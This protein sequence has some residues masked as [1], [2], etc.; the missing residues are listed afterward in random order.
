MP[1]KGYKK[2]YPLAGAPPKPRDPSRP[3]NPRE[4]VEFDPDVYEALCELHCTKAEIAAV[5]NMSDDTLSR[6]IEDHYGQPHAAIYAQKLLRGNVSLR[7]VQRDLA[8][9]NA[10]MAIFLG[11]NDL[12]QSDKV[13]QHITGNLTLEAIL[14]QANTKQEEESKPE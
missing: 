8:K 5:F 4:K 7:K 12:G 2:K 9:E 1:A 10:A 13:E 6:R 11:K 3:T 14:S